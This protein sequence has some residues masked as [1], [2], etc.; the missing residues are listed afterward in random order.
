MKEFPVT[1]PAYWIDQDG[2]LSCT[3]LLD[4]NGT[5]WIFV[6]TNGTVF[7]KHGKNVE[8]RRDNDLK[9]THNKNCTCGIDK[10]GDGIHSSWCD[11]K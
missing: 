4:P 8:F 11:K 2:Y 1:G 6:D 9:I 10:V 7:V 3:T 5:N